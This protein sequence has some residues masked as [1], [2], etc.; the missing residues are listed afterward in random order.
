MAAAGEPQPTYRVVGHLKGKLT[1]TVHG[2]KDLQSVQMMGK[3]DPYC[4]VTLGDQSIK[5]TICRKGGKRPFW[6]ETI[7]FGTTTE[8]VCIIQMMDKDTITADDTIGVCEID[9]QEVKEEGRQAKWLELHYK[10]KLAGEILVE[11]IFMKDKHT[12]E[13]TVYVDG[14][15]VKS[16]APKR[17]SGQK[18]ASKHIIDYKE[19]EPLKEKESEITTLE[20]SLEY[21]VLD[22][23][24]NEEDDS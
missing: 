9:L 8:P 21:R 17:Y 14:A 22:L 5:G 3:M 24:D 15:A 1:V 6:N 12:R 10:R 13:A 19:K 20:E 4:V 23:L 11:S 7:V 18:A 2:A 16:E